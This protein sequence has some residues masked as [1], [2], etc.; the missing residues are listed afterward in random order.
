MTAEYFKICDRNFRKTVDMFGSN[1][2]NRFCFIPL[3]CSLQNLIKSTLKWPNPNQFKKFEE[4]RYFY[5]H[6]P[7]N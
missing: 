6:P 1:V 7:E 5:L 4:D 2:S 3:L